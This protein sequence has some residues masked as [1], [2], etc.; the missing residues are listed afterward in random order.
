MNHSFC[1]WTRSMLFLSLNLLLIN[2]AKERLKMPRETD[3]SRKYRKKCSSKKDVNNY[4]PTVTFDGAAVWLLRFPGIFSDFQSVD[5][6]ADEGKS[7]VSTN[8]SH[9]SNPAEFKFMDE[10]ALLK[11]GR[12]DKDAP[13]H[14]YDRRGPVREKPAT[15]ESLSFTSLSR[16]SVPASSARST[17]LATL[18][19]GTL[20]GE[21]TYSLGH[22]GQLK[23]W[24]LKEGGERWLGGPIKDWWVCFRYEVATRDEQIT[25]YQQNAGQTCLFT[26]KLW[27]Q[28]QLCISIK[29]TLQNSFLLIWVVGLRIL[30]RKIINIYR[31]K[32]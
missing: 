25:V 14:P 1:G 27:T 4:F 21:R 7:P 8:M 13:K 29:I 16:N 20:E 11:R 19:S 23:Y 5:I 31:N 26:F 30:N 6:P 9:C 18:M 15:A 28:D 10:I 17:G 32:C 22:N 24:Q 3:S 12:I 2:W